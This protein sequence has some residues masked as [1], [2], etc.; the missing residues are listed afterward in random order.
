MYVPIGNPVNYLI[1]CNDSVTKRNPK[2]K[3]VKSCI[4]LK[5]PKWQVESH[6]VP[7]VCSINVRFQSSLGDGSPMADSRVRPWK[8]FLCPDC[9]GDEKK[10]VL[11]AL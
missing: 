9:K 2:R 6:P 10:I 11:E 4:I 5:I 8:P 7:E 1:M 3:F